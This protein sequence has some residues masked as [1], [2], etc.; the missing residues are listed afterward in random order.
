M[1]M[2]K[3]VCACELIDKHACKQKYIVREMEKERLHKGVT[4][5]KQNEIL[6][7][8]ATSKKDEQAFG[9]QKA[10]GEEKAIKKNYTSATYLGIWHNMSKSFSP[11]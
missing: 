5:A 8:I 1:S 2:C 4:K 6:G 9:D 10:F 3:Y 11:R 7:C